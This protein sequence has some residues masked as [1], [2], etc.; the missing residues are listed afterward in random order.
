LR[1]VVYVTDVLENTNSLHILCALL[2]YSVTC[3][4]MATDG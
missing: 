1:R 2:V 3:R 4:W